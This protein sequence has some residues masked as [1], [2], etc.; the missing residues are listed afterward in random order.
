M[1]KKSNVE[2]RTEYII[3]R[4]TPTEKEDII[5]K[6]KGN[7]SSYIRPKIFGNKNG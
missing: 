4:V 1:R 7:I 2:T 5:R 3:I 6:S